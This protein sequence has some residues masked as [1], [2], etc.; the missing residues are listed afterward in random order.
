[1]GRRTHD[2]FARAWQVQSAAIL[3]ETA[4][5]ADV[6]FSRFRSEARNI[7]DATL[8]RPPDHRSIALRDST[9]DDLI[10]FLGRLACN[11]ADSVMLARASCYDIGTLRVTGYWSL[12]LILIVALGKRIVR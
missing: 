5:A 3:P 9:M 7:I 1:L 2:A 12:G 8:R 11:L 6:D 10:V 4:A